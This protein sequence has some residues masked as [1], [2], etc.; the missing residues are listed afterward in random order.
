MSIF[1]D[2]NISDILNN[3]YVFVALNGSST[4]KTGRSPL[5]KFS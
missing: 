1:D 2:E 4:W 3:K 5:E